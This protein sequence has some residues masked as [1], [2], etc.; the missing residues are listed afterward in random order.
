[1]TWQVFGRLGS[2]R[3]EN[4]A[5]TT[6]PIPPH[7]VGRSWSSESLN[8][9]SH[10]LTYSMYRAWKTSV[11]LAITSG[12]SHDQAF[13]I[14]RT[15][16]FLCAGRIFSAMKLAGHIPIELSRVLAGF[17]YAADTNSLT[18][19]VCGEWKLVTWAL[20]FLDATDPEQTEKKIADILSVEI[21]K[22]KERYQSF[23]LEIERVQVISRLL[24]KQPKCSIL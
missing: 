6:V 18:A 13:N 10:Q 7:I 2:S 3:T 1:M 11:Q 16:A 21:K 19:A 9:R 14:H 23:E 17:L 4:C 24:S 15:I 20:L 12:A 8:L 22:I 5:C